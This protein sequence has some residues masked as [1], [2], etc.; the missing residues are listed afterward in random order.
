MGRLLWIPAISGL[1]PAATTKTL[2][3]RQK[4]PIPRHRT[5]SANSPEFRPLEGAGRLFLSPSLD[6]YPRPQSQQSWQ[7]ALENKDSQA[8]PTKASP[9]DMAIYLF[10]YN[11][12]CM[13]TAYLQGSTLCKKIKPQITLRATSFLN[14]DVTDFHRLIYFVCS[15]C[16]GV[17]ICEICVSI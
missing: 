6:R 11:G 17:Q 5:K 3:N 16:S 7:L 12:C 13:A 9:K 2:Q 10:V 4:A 15:L 1:Q 14:T 8:V